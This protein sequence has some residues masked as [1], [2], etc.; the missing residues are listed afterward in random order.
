MNWQWLQIEWL[1]LQSATVGV[2]LSFCVS[3]VSSEHSPAHEASGQTR[4][5]KRHIQPARAA[6]KMSKLTSSNCL[7]DA[8][9]CLV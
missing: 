1:E 5:E 7:F 2:H 4:P 8:F 9:L 6:K 3:K